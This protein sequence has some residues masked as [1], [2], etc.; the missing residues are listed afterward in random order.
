MADA[1]LDQ[2]ASPRADAEHTEEPAIADSR[3]EERH[4]SEMPADLGQSDSVDFPQGLA[5]QPQEH[6]EE[7][8]GTVWATFV[9]QPG[10]Y[11]HAVS[12][13]LNASMRQARTVVGGDLQI[14]PEHLVT[15]YNE[16]YV[17][18]DETISQLGIYAGQLG[19]VFDVVV[20]QSQTTFDYHMPAVLT[21]FVKDRK[22]LPQAILLNLTNF[23]EDGAVVNSFPVAVERDT[24]PKPYIGGYRNKKSGA[25]YYHASAQT[26][27]ERKNKWDDKEPRF[28]RETQTMKVKTRSQQTCRET[29]TQMARPDLYID[30]S[31]DTEIVANTYF[32]AA[33]LAALKLEKTIVIQCYWRGYRARCKAW[34]MR[35]QIREQEEMEERKEAEAREEAEKR[36]QRELERRMNPRT[37]K[38]FEVLYN[39][40]ENWRV[41][42]K[43][44]IDDAELPEEERLEALAQLL[45][46]E[47]KLLQTIDNM[48]TK[49]GKVTKAVRVEKNLEALAA[50]KKW[51]MADGE[52]ATVHTPF[53]TRAK[54][55]LDLYKGLLSKG[56]PVE[57]RLDILLHVKWT[58]KEFDC[59][60]TR[61]IV[62]LVDREADLLNRGRNEK[63]LQC[64]CIESEAAELL[65]CR[66]T[67]GGNL[68]C[69]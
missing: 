21:I 16:V 62:D 13:P 28:S 9:V 40:V 33:E 53:T 15:K 30:D 1:N 11:S 39:E 67:V 38:D 69:E 10:G 17:P 56:R 52:V 26:H 55:L 49:A 29:S 63:S 42:E 8:V 41:A 68:F 3:A 14:P 4:E 59:Q 44:K 18:P 34:D 65:F 64:K 25:V 19:V 58:V 2:N 47:T 45:D 43:A 27:V 7:D 24:A 48:K 66:R 60:L 5:Q 37:K 50:P 35:G 31:G 54:E 23:A 61:E 32:T 20:D 57:E 46:K 6:Y 36:H 22:F 51:Q 12:L